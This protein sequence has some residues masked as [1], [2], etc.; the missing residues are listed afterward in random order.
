MHVHQLADRGD[1]LR[2]TVLAHSK[3]RGRISSALAKQPP[4]GDPRSFGSYYIFRAP[5]PGDHREQFN[6]A[7]DRFL[8]AMSQRA[9][10]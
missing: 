5:A 4:R 9:G 1:P 3:Y 2:G 10:A 8:E 6:A 7:S